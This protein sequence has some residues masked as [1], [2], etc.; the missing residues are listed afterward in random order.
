MEI[1]EPLAFKGREGSGVPGGRNAYAD[2][3]LEPE[4]GDW[5]KFEYT[6]RVLGRSLYSPHVS[7]ETWDRYLRRD[8]GAG[9]EHVYVA[10][11]EAGRLLPTVTQA[12]LP[13]AANQWYWPELYTH[14]QIVP[15]NPAPYYDSPEPLSFGTAD[16]MDPQLFTTAAEH[17]RE[18]LTGK[19]SGKYTQLEV[20]VW[21]EASATRSGEALD[22][23]RKLVPSATSP[24]FRRVEEDVLIQNSLGLFFA[25][26]FRAGLFYEICQQTGDVAAGQMALAQ[27]TKARDIWASMAERAK[28]VYRPNIAYGDKYDRRGHW[29]DRYC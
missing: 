5:R 19:S 18:L 23:A 6:Y 17:A 14:M 29:T 28:T 3:S 2:L 25:A 16:P 10:L 7:S 15:G 21:L 12:Y 1:F 27:L 24:A 22:A 20:A 13:S 11:S 8:F 9:A 4:G 26:K